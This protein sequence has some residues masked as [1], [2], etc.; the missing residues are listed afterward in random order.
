MFAEVKVY[1]VP[2]PTHCAEGVSRGGC[3]GLTSSLIRELLIQL[4][5]NK[6]DKRTEDPLQ[7]DDPLPSPWGCAGSVWGTRRWRNISWSPSEIM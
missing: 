3:M 1:C 5:A 4:I 2:T 7:R 6:R